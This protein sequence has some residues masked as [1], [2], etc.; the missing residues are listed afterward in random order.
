MLL[1]TTSVSDSAV[2][3]YAGKAPVRDE[4]LATPLSHESSPKV[5]AP[6]PLVPAETDAQ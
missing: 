1:T 4:G 3:M 2:W 5:V 6:S